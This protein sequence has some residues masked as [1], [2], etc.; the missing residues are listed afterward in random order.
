MKMQ[1]ALKGKNLKLI[2]LGNKN[3][4][5]I[6]LSSSNDVLQ[7]LQYFCAIF[8]I[9]LFTCPVPVADEPDA[10]DVAEIVAWK[11][12]KLLNEFFNQN[13]SEI[14]L[15]NNRGKNLEILFQKV[16]PFRHRTLIT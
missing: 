3:T 14:M 12:N 1:R 8:W 16:F 11:K 13:N 2:K 15:Q 6:L 4:W 9:F 5:M 10:P 7:S